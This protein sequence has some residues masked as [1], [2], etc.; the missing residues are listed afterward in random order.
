LK[1]NKKNFQLPLQLHVTPDN[2]ISN[3][4]FEEVVNGDYTDMDICENVWLYRPR[5][6]FWSSSYDDNDGSDWI[7]TNLSWGNGCSMI[8]NRF[9][10]L[11]FPKQNLS[12]YV[13]DTKEDLDKIMERFRRSAPTNKHR[14]IPFLDFEKLAQHVDGLHVTKNGVRLLENTEPYQLKYWDCESTLWFHLD[15]IEKIE[16]KGK[17]N[18]KTFLDNTP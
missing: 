1:S 5:G 17:I 2:Q 4:N 10:F 15:W 12:L 11:L 7:Q 13:L 8:K 14:K 6:G 9:Q 18:I 3:N 16:E